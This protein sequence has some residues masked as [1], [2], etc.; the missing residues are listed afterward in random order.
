MM[1]STWRRATSQ[2][3]SKAQ[4]VTFPSYRLRDV[5]TSVGGGFPGYKIRL[6]RRNHCGRQRSAHYSLGISGFTNCMALSLKTIRKI[7][8]TPFDKNRDGFV[9]AKRRRIDT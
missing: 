7:S 3:G 6:R 5:Q 2:S 1:I 4:G 8:S 9:M